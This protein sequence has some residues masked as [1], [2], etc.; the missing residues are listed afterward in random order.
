MGELI[1]V[2][3]ISVQRREPCVTVSKKQISFNS[4]M[5]NIIGFDKNRYVSVYVDDE[6]KR[7]AFEFKPFKS[8]DDD[9][10]IR[11]ANKYPNIRCRELFSKDWIPES[12]TEK[13]KNIFEAKQKNEKWIITLDTKEI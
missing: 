13:G 5:K 2:K 1:K 11:S 10:K 4:A 12:S 9:F 8:S 7:I 6:G 3:K